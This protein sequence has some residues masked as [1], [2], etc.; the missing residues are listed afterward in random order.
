MARY[1]QDKELEQYRSLMEP[2]EHF[3]DGFTWKTVVGAVF[4]GM[5]IMP[6]SMYLSLVVGPEANMDTAARWVTIILF[7]EI[8]R[9]SFKDLKMQEI[10]IFYYMAGLAMASPFQGL[11]WNQYLVQSDYANAMGVAQEIP[12]W[13]APSAEVIR[14]QGHTF[15]TKAWLGPIMLIIVGLLVSRLDQYGFGYVLYRITNDVEELPFPMAPVAAAGIT[16]LAQTKEDKERWRWRCF[17]IGAIL[18]LTFGLF[19]I[20]IPSISGALL[21]KPIQPLPIPWQDFTPALSKILPATP[22]NISF[23]LLWF[24]QGM[25]LP[26]WAVIGGAFGVVFTMGLN[27]ILYK[28]GVLSHWD[29]QMDVINTLYSNNVDFYLSFSLGLTLA[30]TVVSLGKI[31]TPM[32]NAWRNRRGNMSALEASVTGQKRESTWRRLLVND[33][34][35]G[36]FSIWIALCIYVLT[37]GFWIGLSCWLIE[38]FPWH[39]F[40][41]YALVLT[42]LLSYA[43]AKLEGLCGQALSIPYIREATYILSGYKGVKI[44]FAPVPIPNYGVETVNFRVL[45]LTGTKISSQIKTQIVTVPIIIIASIVFSTM[46]WSMAEVPSA[47]Y[48]YAQKMWELNAKNTCLTFSSTMEGGSMFMEAL[49]L[50]YVLVG[51]GS[52]VISFIVL[53]VLGLPTLLVFGMV[54]GLGQ[55]TPSGVIFELL[56]ALIGRFYFKKRFGDQWM[57][58]TPI[59]LAGFS[60]GMGLIGMVSVAFTILN[61]MM[62][63]LVF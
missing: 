51:L 26:F 54:R 36:D 38:G 31:L 47:A 17:S 21:D 19:Y 33:P 61:K 53:S 27:P 15:F 62:A 55:S 34:K 49:R 24:F 7:A 59:L 23:N 46:L 42:P 63:P 8:A 57:K 29:S 14:E 3:E 13:W 48:P 22:L 52:G 56:G 30:I 5:L 41:F 4:L 58:Y 50:K 44:W 60:C 45:E 40:V 32:M 9:R 28:Y 6:G 39:F 10:Y 2:P 25:V 16:A 43:T 18:G 37:N 20:A 1:T 35:R 12:S 11:L